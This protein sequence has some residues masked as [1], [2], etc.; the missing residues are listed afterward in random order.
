[1]APPTR[2]TS[3]WRVTYVSLGPW[4]AMAIEVL[5][6]IRRY[7]SLAEG[8]GFGP[9]RRPSTCQGWERLPVSQTGGFNHSPTPPLILLIQGFHKLSAHL[10][11]SEDGTAPLRI[12][13]F[14]DHIIK[15]EL[16]LAGSF[17][18]GPQMPPHELCREIPELGKRQFEVGT[19][20][21]VSYT[22][23]TLPTNREV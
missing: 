23:L 1:M 4:Q 20:E 5:L 11:H 15:T 21:S 19:Q 16:A 3:G 10:R 8:T 22:H 6:A 17:D 12:R 7:L 13:L 18:P 9:A 2:L 14:L